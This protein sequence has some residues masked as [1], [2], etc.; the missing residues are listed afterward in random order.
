MSQ[1]DTD[2]STSPNETTS[3][4]TVGQDASPNS[5]GHSNVDNKSRQN[6]GSPLTN[7]NPAPKPNPRSCVTC[8]KRKVRCDKGHPCAN[9]NRAGIECI[10]PGPG[11]APRRSRKPP[12]TELL[13][14]LRRLEGVVQNLGKN[15][16][17]EPGTIDGEGPPD[18][19]AT[20]TTTTV[21]AAAAAAATTTK[22]AT[23]D[24]PDGGSQCSKSEKKIPNRCGMFNGPKPS[25]DQT[26][27]VV[28]EFG[29]LVVDEG[30]SRYVSN[31]FWNSLSE[32]VDEMRD[33]LDDPTDDEDDYPSPGSGSSAS[34]NHQGFIFSF[35]STILDL[36]R[37]H[38]PANHVMTYW[39]I[40][41]ENVDPL[42]KILHRIETEKVMI[43]AA[44][45]LEHISKPTEVM[46][47]SI[48]FAAVTSL[49]E[50]ECLNITGTD[51]DT[52]LKNYR[53]AFEQA[54]ARAGFLGTTELVV[55]QSFV[56]FLICV[57]RHDDSRF[58]WT[59]TGLL[60]RL[61]QSLG[62]HRDGK[63]F[64]LTPYEIELRR[65]LWWQIVHLDLRASEDH[66]SDPTILDQSFDTMF[67]LNI[68]DSD[69]CPSTKEMPKEREGATEM[70]FDLIR[71]TVST[72]AR[73]L[74]YAPPGPGKCRERS[75]KFT[76]E[77]KERL[78]EELHQHIER[79]Y[80]KHCDMTIPLHWV[81]G[82]VLRLVLAK[83][84]MIV[85]HPLQRED[86]GQGL[87][88]ETKDRL[89]RTSVEVVEWSHLLEIESS[90]KKWGW[91]FRTYVQWHAV[92]FVLSQLC[93]RTEGSEVEKAWTVIRAILD[94]FGGTVSATKR[95][96]L[97]K[98]LRKLLA[99]AEASRAKALE[100]RAV[101]PLD[102]SLG[103]AIPSVNAMNDP[104]PI[105]TEN[106]KLMAFDPSAMSM[107]SNG[108]IGGL[109][110]T[111]NGLTHYMSIDQ[112]QQ[113]PPPPAGV[114]DA[115]LWNYNDPAFPEMSRAPGGFPSMNGMPGMRGTEGWENGVESGN[116]PVRTNSGEF[117]WDWDDVMKDFPM[118]QEPGLNSGP[119]MGGM[120]NWW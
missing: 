53:F 2:F 17:E 111:T 6:T 90:T 100:K 9:C 46:M 61:A 112:P 104:F 13:A 35:S 88:Q 81:A 114:V 102:G 106:T 78:I 87:S 95:G 8:R 50:D 59:L 75:N 20:T 86:L 28:R 29:R 119:V 107:A 38:P 115:S 11:R 26:N 72:T 40:Y 32:E 74:T 30:R 96:M 116:G 66:G 10:F 84:W 110:P 39:E 92:A 63:Q 83:M 33:I 71:Y 18:D 52:A 44:K 16:D 73:R 68:N 85:H 49:S 69:I 58:V 34:A 79:K 51:K 93:V 56:I 82:T 4:A 21:A 43:E 109:F 80:L 120:T 108:D 37:F 3:P 55:V 12:D 67:P 101:F 1:L 94:D 117:S 76:L 22:T 14:R 105:S 45:D 48:Y 99:R 7:G 65:R 23:E 19:S 47:F 41:K 5:S 57:R 97:W 113:P 70:T 77:D 118:E 98:P 24:G 103:P 25:S 91:L 31:K 62:L 54:M 15:I 60:I 64:G 36:Y 42:I 89:F 27:G